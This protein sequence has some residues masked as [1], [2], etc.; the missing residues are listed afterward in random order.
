[1]RR[2][3][4]RESLTG[5]GKLVERARYEFSDDEPNGSIELS[6]L[7]G[8]SRSAWCEGIVSLRP[9]SWNDSASA[10]RGPS[11][12]RRLGHAVSDLVLNRLDKL[13]G[14]PDRDL[15]VG[16]DPPA[17][18]AGPPSLGKVAHR[19]SFRERTGGVV[20]ISHEPAIL[21]YLDAR[22]PWIGT[23]TRLDSTDPKAGSVCVIRGESDD[24][25]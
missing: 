5:I 15:R 11:G 22:G 7:A 23:S 2:A 12:G 24:S 9:T 21:R 10:Q 19:V 17:Q 18:T 13:Q 16:N 4:D 6:P 20:R 1:M 14:Y 25:S 8:S 3:A